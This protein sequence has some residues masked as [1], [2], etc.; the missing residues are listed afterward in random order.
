VVW[1]AANEAFRLEHRKRRSDRHRAQPELIGE[2]VQEQ[3]AAGAQL[4][5][6][7]RS[8]QL[9]VDLLDSR[10]QQDRHR[11]TLRRSGQARA[12]PLVI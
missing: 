12:L 2:L 7:D 10:P 8:A 4:V 5:S 1:N 9:L 11:T 3:R 6:H